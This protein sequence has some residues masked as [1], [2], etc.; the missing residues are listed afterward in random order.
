MGLPWFRADTNFPTHDKVLDLMEHG[1][2]G[3]AAGFVYWCSLA[4]SVGNG[5][6]GVIKKAALAFVHGTAADARL[7]V[8]H[9]L[10]EPVDGGWRIKNFGTRQVVGAMQ[11]VIEDSLAQA[12]SENG[13]KGAQARW[14]NE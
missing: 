2:K 5:S 3:K 6:D 9:G 4:L 10:W 13:R 7:L 14:G 11:Q 12:R 8:E 1:S